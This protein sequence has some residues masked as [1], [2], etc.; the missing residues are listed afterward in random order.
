[1]LIMNKEETK[2]LLIEEL[3]IH[4]ENEYSLPP[5]AARIFASLVI[6]EEEGLTFD[7][8]LTKRGASKSS[9]STSLNLL[10]QMNFVKYFTK[11]GD[12]RRYFKI[13]EKDAFFIKKLNKTLKK[14]E[15]ESEIIEKVVAF[16]KAY[17]AEKHEANK[18]KKRIYMKC[19]EDTKAIYKKT[20]I[21]LKNLEQ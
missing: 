11:S 21:N 17:N 18:E 2:K 4:F 7:D 10:L 15:D 12:R 16:N 8:C 1:M 6:T 14:L 20:I 9:I 3:G 5:L 19:L 13:A